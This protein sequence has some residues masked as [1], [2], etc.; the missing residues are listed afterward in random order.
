MHASHGVPQ[1]LSI[2]KNG[3]CRRLLRGMRTR[4]LGCTSPCW[5]R[6][7]N[8]HPQRAPSCMRWTV[9][10]QAPPLHAPL[11]PLQ[12]SSLTHPARKI[13]ISWALATGMETRSVEAVVAEAA[14]EQV[15]GRAVD[16]PPRLLLLPLLPLQQ[17]L[18]RSILLPAARPHPV[19]LAAKVP[20]QS[21]VRTW[22]SKPCRKWTQSQKQQ[23]LSLLQCQ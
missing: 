10:D 22:K 16:P 21:R 5:V 23:N 17:P 18:L 9:Q 12:S 13:Q 6:I 1:V 8:Q 4:T 3:P 7:P 11:H 2:W 20:K 14:V 19:P 15:V